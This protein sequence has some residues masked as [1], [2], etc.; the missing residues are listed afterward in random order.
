MVSVDV[1]LATER[2]TL[3]YL[4]DIATLDDFSRAV[5]DAG[6]SVEGIAG[7]E[8]EERDRERLGPHQVSSRTSATG[9]SS[10]AALA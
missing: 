6:Y 1:N 9:F 7:E 8:E 5:G 3:H 10:L 2:A 4:D